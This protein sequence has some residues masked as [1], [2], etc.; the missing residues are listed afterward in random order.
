MSGEAMLVFDEG[1]T[2]Y[3][4]GHGHPMS[5][6]RVDLTMQLTRSL[7]LLDG[8]GLLLGQI[9]EWWR[10]LGHADLLL[11]L[12]I[13]PVGRNATPNSKTWALSC[14]YLLAT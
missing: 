9:G 13:W 2:A 5:P 4:F 12:T 7:G 6:I 11:R 14:Q 10:V 8:S 3:D 1:L